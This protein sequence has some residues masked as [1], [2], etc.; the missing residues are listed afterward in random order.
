MSRVLLNQCANYRAESALTHPG[1]TRFTAENAEDA[2]NNRKASVG[3]R[4]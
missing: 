3:F 4:P 1:E 2:E